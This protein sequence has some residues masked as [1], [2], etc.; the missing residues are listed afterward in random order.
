MNPKQASAING[1]VADL[2][3]R[4]SAMGSEKIVLGACMIHSPA[5]SDTRP[6]I[7]ASDFYAMAHGLIWSAICALADRG[8]P[9]D[10]EAVHR[11]LIENDTAPAVYRTLPST[12]LID[13]TARDVTPTVSNATWH[14]NQV[15]KAAQNRAVS[16]LGE[17]L[18]QMAHGNLDPQEKLRMILD[19]A[20]NLDESSRFSEKQDEVKSLL[21]D[22]A[23]FVL[24]IPEIPPAVWGE[25]GDILWAQG[26]SLMIAGPEGVGKTTLATQLIR[27]RLGLCS[28]V[29][30]MPVRPG[31]KKVLYLAMDR[32]AQARR[33][34]NRAFAEDERSVLAERLVVWQGPP[35]EDMAQNTGLLTQMAEKADADTV[36]V[37]SLKDAAVGLSEDAVGSAWNRSR[38]KLLNTGCELL[39]LHH[40]RK[41]GTN[42][43]PPNTLADVYGSRWLAAGAGSVVALWGEAGDPIVAMRHLKQPMNEI[44]P[45]KIAHDH[46]RGVSSIHHAHDLKELVRLSGTKGLTAKAAAVA[47]FE[48]D[49]PNAAEVE[50]ARRRLEKLITQGH[51]ASVGG[52]RGG[53]QDRVASTY[54]LA[55]PDPA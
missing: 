38:Q 52:G 53:G 44:G 40:N 10:P 39:E 35:P 31:R 33:A 50:R 45:F 22:G 12:Y 17:K 48:K 41:A 28:E 5:L 27:G 20:Q 1:Q 9:Y 15:R 25:G 37:D 34:L 36:F 29:L 54:Y 16:A 47:L 24:D 13:L 21:V 26:E 8:E 2:S 30:G 18:R 23:S 43:A 49:N 14:A 11:E 4:D 3:A 32:P 42:G 7:S 51:L 19:E 55:C 6:L 46:Q